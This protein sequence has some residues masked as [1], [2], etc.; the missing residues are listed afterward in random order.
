M[1]YGTKPDHSAMEARNRWKRKGP[2]A[3][4]W[5]KGLVFCIRNKRKEK[6]FYFFFFHRKT[7]SLQRRQKK[8]ITLALVFY[9]FF[10][11]LFISQQ[12]LVYIFF[13][14]FLHSIS[15]FKVQIVIVVQGMG[16]HNLLSNSSKNH[17]YMSFMYAVFFVGAIDP[18]IRMWGLSFLISFVF[19]LFRLCFSHKTTYL[20]TLVFNAHRWDPTFTKKWC[21]SYEWSKFITQPTRYLYSLATIS[22]PKYNPC[23]SIVLFVHF[24]MCS[25]D[26]HW[27]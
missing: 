19:L 26:L 9:C 7:R 8:H 23:M 24:P 3:W 1:H 17:I 6:P 21:L 20:E 10:F 27:I 18:C 12:I 15:I 16:P 13:F 4:F 22:Y 2:Q 11:L 5:V 14:G 25:N